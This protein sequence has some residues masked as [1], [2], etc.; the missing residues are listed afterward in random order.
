VSTIPNGTGR[1]RQV[2]EDA[3]VGGG[4]L[5]DLTVLATQN[6]PYRVDTPAGHRD[7][8]WFAEQFKAAGRERIHPRGLHYAVV[9]AEH[10]VLKPNGK[11]YQ[12]DDA[13]WTW[14]QGVAAKAARW[15]GYVPFDAITDER[16]SPPV[17]HRQEPPDPR[18]YLSVGVEIEIPAADEIEPYVGAFEFEGR[19]PNHLVIFGEKSSLADV[20]LPIAESCGADLYLPTGEISDTLLYQ[21]AKDGAADGRPMKVFTLAD[22]DPAGYQMP[23]SIG[24]KLQAFRDLEFPDLDFEVLPVT[25]AADQVREFNIP[26][27]P[28]KD[29]ERRAD[30]WRAAFG[31]EQT[32]VDALATL[33]PELLRSIVQDAIAPYFDSTLDVRVG[34]AYLRWREAAQAILDQHIDGDYLADLHE[35]AAAKLV[36]IEDE[37]AKLNE[38]LRQAAPGWLTMLLPEIE[39]PE[40]E[41]DESAHGKPL[42]SARWPWVEQTRALIERKSYGGAP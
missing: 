6:D 18:P 20:L 32:E 7:G 3:R 11:P 2:I 39:I 33:R 26:S 29:T 16:N 41:I 21:M 25:L 19:Q 37:I 23:I 4:S 27:T 14:L 35:V 31:V 42:I 9:M 38:A 24:R 34:R 22:F 36:E 8:Q 40:P 30:R 12:N 17:I 13:N 15:L 10:V 1:L 5:K 28:L